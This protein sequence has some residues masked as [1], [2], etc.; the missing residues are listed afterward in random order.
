MPDRIPARR[1]HSGWL[2][3]AAAIL[4]VPVVSSAGIIIEDK[5]VSLISR[6]LVM[7]Q[8][9]PCI[10]LADLA[11]ALGGTLQVD[12][13]GRRLTITPGQGGVLKINP[14]S[15]VLTR[16]NVA[17]GQAAGRTGVMLRLGGG[18]VMTEDFERILLRPSPLMPLPLLAKLLGGTAR[19]DPSKNMWVLPHG[20]PGD[21][22]A[23]R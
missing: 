21:P 23:F 13:P 19:L 20:G 3:I 14:G 15:P 12:L 9:V 18:D 10:P 4:A 7:E 17:A 22:L 1:P 16:S 5:P 6:N 2:A 8:G 11:R